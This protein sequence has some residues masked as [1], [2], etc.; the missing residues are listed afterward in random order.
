MTSEESTA[1]R[2]GMITRLEDVHDFPCAFVFKVI[3]TN[4]SN[5]AARVTG[6]VLM[7]L[8]HDTDPEITTRES[9]G[10]KHLSVTVTAHC[11]TADAVLDVY[12]AVQGVEGVKMTL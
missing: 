10:G 4:A 12:E 3:G 2:E 5:F 7:A 11:E 6:A 8:G 1:Q 9:S